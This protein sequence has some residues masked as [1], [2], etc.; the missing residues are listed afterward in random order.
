MKTA[1]KSHDYAAP[2]Q[3]AR[4]REPKWKAGSS[5]VPSGAIDLQQ[6]VDA[7][8]STPAYPEPYV[9]RW[10]TRRS[11]AVAVGI[12]A[13]LWGGIAGLAALAFR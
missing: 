7:A 9:E 6:R 3:E 10:S 2:Q 11:L 12:S 13:A 1:R 8:F 4:P 5:P